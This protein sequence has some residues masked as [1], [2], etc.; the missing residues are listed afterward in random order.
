M[1]PKTQ[2]LEQISVFLENR[3]GVIAEVCNALIDQDINIAA[4]SVLDTFDI[5]TMRLVV[6]RPD[7]AKEALRTAGAAYVAVPV[8]G[9]TMPNVPGALGLFGERIA[10]VGVNI[11]YMYAS[12]IPDTNSVFAIVRVREVDMEKVLEL[13]FDFQP[14][15]AE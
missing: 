6:D 4:L 2:M 9:V 7:A 10:N 3:P 11:E 14:S 1:S 12:S 15:T 5:A 8:L 13:D